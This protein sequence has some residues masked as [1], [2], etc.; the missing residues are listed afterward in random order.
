MPVIPNVAKGVGGS[1]NTNHMT[2][3]ATRTLMLHPS[4][5]ILLVTNSVAPAPASAKPVNHI[6]NQLKTLLGTQKYEII[7]NSFRSKSKFYNQ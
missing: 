1:I 4:I 6:I 7:T 3:P 2:Q 5:L